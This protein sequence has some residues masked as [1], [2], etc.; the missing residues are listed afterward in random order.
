[1]DSPLHRLALSDGYVLLVGV[2]HTSNATVHVGEAVGKAPY[3]DLPYSDAFDVPMTIRLPDGG[4]EIMYPRENPGCSINFNIIEEPL[5]TSGAIR[6]GAIGQAE[7]RLMRG[8]DIIDVVSSMLKAD[9]SALLC[10]IEW[11]PFCLRARA[12][13]EG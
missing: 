7:S 5:R 2:H 8:I 1:V 12:L 10:D 4:T 6:Y 3:L 9:A 13:V 11:C